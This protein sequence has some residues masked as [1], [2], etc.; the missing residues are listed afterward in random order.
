[1]KKN[2]LKIGAFALCATVALSA[3]L[4]LS[5]CGKK[6]ACIGLNG[7]DVYTYT[8]NVMSAKLTSPNVSE[9]DCVVTVNVG[10]DVDEVEFDL[11]KF[12]ADNAGY[13]GKNF[14]FTR[15]DVTKG[16]GTLLDGYAWVQTGGDASNRLYKRMGYENDETVTAINKAAIAALPDRQG[17]VRMYFITTGSQAGK[18]VVYLDATTG[19]SVAAGTTNVTFKFCGDNKECAELKVQVVKAV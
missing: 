5:G 11:Q 2:F 3:L 15:S 16:D 7:T 13:K 9:K 19:S 17:E 8:N 4:G 12:F 1:M 18:A 10:A 14:T 6:T